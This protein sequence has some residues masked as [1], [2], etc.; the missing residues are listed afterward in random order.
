MHDNAFVFMHHPP[1]PFFFG[2]LMGMGVSVVDF[3]K[4][5]HTFDKYPPVARM[6]VFHR[7]AQR[8]EIEDVRS[9]KQVLQS[10]L[11]FVSYWPCRSDKIGWAGFSAKGK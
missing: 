11:V 4:I 6:N 9:L 7:H 3:N 10:S 1:K 2:Q 5:V 8:V